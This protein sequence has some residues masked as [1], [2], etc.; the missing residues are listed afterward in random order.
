M[1]NRLARA[2]AILRNLE[3]TERKRLIGHV[4]AIGAV[5]AAVVGRWI[6]GVGGAPFSWFFAAITVSA[7]YGGM[8]PALVAA[9]ASLLAVRITTDV[10]LGA[11]L[12]FAAEGIAIALVVVVLRASRDGERK[13]FSAMEPWMREMK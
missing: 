6:F 3:T 9:L 13:R 10:P 7:A 5:A 8:A 1:R 4:V 11:A 2:S 12:L